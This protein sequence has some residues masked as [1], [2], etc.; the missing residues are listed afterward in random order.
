MNKPLSISIFCLF[1]VVSLWAQQEPGT[2][3]LPSK[4]KEIP[5]VELNFSI[6]GGFYH[7]SLQIEL[8]S[9]G[10]KIYYSLDGTKP[11]GYATKYR[12]PIQIDKTT[13]IR[14]IAYLGKRKSKIIARTYFID[15]PTSTIPVVSIGITPSVLFDPEFG[16]YVQGPN[17][18]DSL[19]TKDGANFWSKREVKVNSEIYLS[20]GECVFN[21]ESG[22]RLFGGMSRLFPQKSMTLVARDDYGKKRIRHRFF[23]KQGLKKFK[24]LVLR[25]SGSD[26]GKSHFRDAMMT[27][28]LEDWNMEKQDCQPAHIYLNGQYWGIYNIREKINRYFLA[29]HHDIDKDSIDLMEHRYSLKRGSRRH[30]LSMLRYLKKNS[31]AEDNKLAYLNSLMDIDNFLDYQIAQ[32]YFDNR[33]AGGNIRFWRPQIPQG[34]WRW[35]LYDT[36]WGF[37]LHDPRAYTY[38]SFAFHTKADGPSWPNPPWSTF[39]LRNLLENKALQ[40]KFINRFSDYMNTTFAAERVVEH[41]DFHYNRLKPEM[42]RQ[43]KR[44]RLSKKTWERHV[45]QMRTFA[46]QRAKYVR[47]HLMERFDTGREA[48]L[49][50]IASTGGR[51]VIN[52]NVDVRRESFKGQY[53]ENIPIHIKAI[54]NF[55][56]RFSHWGGMEEREEARE[57]SLRLNPDKPL[58][59]QAIFVPYEHPLAGQVMI[60]EIS[61][62]DKKTGDWIE[63]YNKS[64]ETVDLSNWIITDN[65][66]E[67]RLPR[68]KISP[69]G[70]YILCQDTTAFSEQFPDKYHRLGNLGFGL[71]KRKEQLGLFTPDGAAVDSFSYNILPTD[72]TFTFSLLL[73]HLDNSDFENWEINFGQGTP[74]S[75]NPFYLESSIRAEQELWMRVGIGIGLL[76][77]CFLVLHM[78]RRWQSKVPAP[79]IVASPPPPTLPE[80]ASESPE[81]NPNTSEP[82]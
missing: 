72:S 33:D 50:A 18:I 26:W 2:A 12:G 63:L 64:K 1:L 3:K 69:K 73:P 23:G 71:N 52:E 42:P 49:Q 17:A 6:E 70:Y 20:D 19:W 60:N 27:G 77:S 43:L 29:D 14:A 80:S 31:M 51:I 11:N 53:F 56:Y 74:E 25:N 54:P 81:E 21:S 75:A 36:D 7:E 66:N 22:F 59:I 76:L 47:M 46:R 45:R 67:Y 65:K 24:F 30:Y 15:E 13:V 35:I 37:G 55:G 4:K 10:A 82:N 38:N 32:I 9:P 8:F 68:A 57:L 58:R 40:H 61:A 62:N 48:E 41:I 78:R 16:L 39:I 28:L 44:W 34:R 79:V 5:P